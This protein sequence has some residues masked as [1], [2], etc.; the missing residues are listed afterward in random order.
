MGNAGDWYKNASAKGLATAVPGAISRVPAG[1][2]V[3][4]G[5][6]PKNSF[7]HVGV[8]QSN[9][10]QTGKLTITEMND[11]ANFNSKKGATSNLGVQTTRVLS[12]SDVQSRPVYS[13]GALSSTYALQGFVLPF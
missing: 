1:S 12:Y 10:P 5:N 4:W 11:G 9:N 3:V 2:I 13:G 7:G 6:N 8:V